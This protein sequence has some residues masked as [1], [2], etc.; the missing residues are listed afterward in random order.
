MWSNK[1]L[2]VLWNVW[3]TE[4]K[5]L[6]SECYTANIIIVFEQKCCWSA[7]LQYIFKHVSRKI[8]MHFKTPCILHSALVFCC[9]LHNFC[10]ESSAKST[11]THVW[12]S[13]I[14]RNSSSSE[15]SSECFTFNA[16]ICA[17]FVDYMICNLTVHLKWPTNEAV[18]LS[19]LILRK[20]I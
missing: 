17:Y 13:N 1:G 15:F 12:I 18:S 8:K 3:G 9:Y 14:H 20:E 2:Q 19:E 16:L 5:H 7:F 11:Q 4:N 10:R 6:N